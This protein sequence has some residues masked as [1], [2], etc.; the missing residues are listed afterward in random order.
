ML[1]GSF[2]GESPGG[3]ISPEP[4]PGKVTFLCARLPA[5][6]LHQITCARRRLSHRK[7]RGRNSP[8]AFPWES[9]ISARMV[10][11]CGFTSNYTCLPTLFLQKARGGEI[12]PEILVFYIYCPLRKETSPSRTWKRL[13]ERWSCN[14]AT[15]QNFNSLVFNCDMRAVSQS[16]AND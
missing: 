1:A 15:W 7:P 6:D 2:P 12:P 4:L 3:K 10:A 13:F 5:A 8:R 16:G 9:D 14:V 11:S